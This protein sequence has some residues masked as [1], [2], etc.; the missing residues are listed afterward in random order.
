MFTTNELPATTENH[1]QTVGPAVNGKLT[2]GLFEAAGVA[3]T[4][5]VPAAVS[6]LKVG[7]HQPSK[8]EVLRRGDE[9]MTRLAEGRSWADWIAVMRVLDIARTT[10]MLE[11]NSNKPQGPKYRAAISKWYRLHETYQAI[12]KSDRSR[13][14]KCFDNLDAINGWREKHVPEPQRLKLNYPTQ[15]LSRW[16]SWKKKQA[17]TGKGEGKGGG[18]G[19]GPPAGPKLVDLW[20]GASDEDRCK[21][22]DLAGR[23]G[24]AK[25][26][27]SDLLAELAD[28]AIGQQINAAAPTNSKNLLVTLTQI[29][30]QA[31]YAPDQDAMCVAFA[32]FRRKCK[33]SRLDPRNVCVSFRKKR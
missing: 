22:F 10:A 21:L 28:H 25:Y 27:S 30:I 15:V 9:A 2:T 19:G 5:A 33:A 13:L 23:G 32:A 29:L 14:L 8:A 16:E 18:G 7:E 11:A 3:V 6:S 31:V 20:P 17:E 12:D 26:V 24:L 1:T 4:A